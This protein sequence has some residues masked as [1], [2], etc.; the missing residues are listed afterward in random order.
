MFL[1]DKT[2]RLKYERMS[3]SIPLEGTWW[4]QNIDGMAV[5][6]IDFEANKS[7][8]HD[9]LYVKPEKEAAEEE[10]ESDG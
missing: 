5:L 10:A 2:W 7:Y 6:G 3:G 4:D 1:R 8:L 9:N